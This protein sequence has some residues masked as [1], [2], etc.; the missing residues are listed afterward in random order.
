MYAQRIRR[1]EKK[2]SE[3]TFE[4]KPVVEYSVRCGAAQDYK[5]F[6]LEYLRGADHA[7]A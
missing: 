1:T 5:K 4:K 2:V 6:V 7:D 3:S